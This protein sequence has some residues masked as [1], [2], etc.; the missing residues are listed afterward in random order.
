MLQIFIITIL[1]IS[2]KNSYYSWSN[3]IYEIL[4]LI[5]KSTANVQ[6]ES[7]YQRKLRDW[8]F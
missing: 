5:I 8:R 6:V 4:T 3:D 1:K 7:K 2:H